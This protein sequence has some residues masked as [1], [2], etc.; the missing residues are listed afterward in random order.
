[1]PS[2]PA[3][4]KRSRTRARSSRGASALNTACF[5]RSDVGRVRPR[6]VTARAHG[7]TAV[8]RCTAHPTR[9]FSAGAAPKR[10]WSAPAIPGA[11]V[12]QIGI[13]LER[14]SA[15]RA[16]PVRARPGPGPDRRPADRDAVLAEPDRPGVP[17]SSPSP[18][19]SVGRARR[20]ESRRSG[21]Q[22]DVEPGLRDI[23][24]RI[25]TRMH[26]D[27]RTPRPTRPRS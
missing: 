9:T 18:A 5:T 6:R 14:S 10:L 26:D 23:G 13:D 2:R 4:A 7:E 19:S 15:P 3:P 24:L 11:P 1:M 25:A 27:S 12:R 16:G 21:L 8:T 20:S 22:H 17:S